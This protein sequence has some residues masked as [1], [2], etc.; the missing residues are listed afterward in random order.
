MKSQI[1]LFYYKEVARGGERTRVLSISF[2]FPFFTT[3]PLSHSGPDMAFC[4]MP[5]VK[6]PARRGRWLWHPICKDENSQFH[7]FLGICR[8]SFIQFLRV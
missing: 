8:V 5:D 4:F 6:P 7:A 1:W 2:I 3:L